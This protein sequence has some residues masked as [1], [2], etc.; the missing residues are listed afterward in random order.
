MTNVNNQIAN[1]DDQLADIKSI[2]FFNQ[3]YAPQ[4]PRLNAKKYDIMSYQASLYLKS[5]EG[6]NVDGKKILDIGC[7][8]GGGLDVFERFY[9][10]ESVHGCDISEKRVQFAK[11]NCVGEIN[12]KVS[13]F[14]SLDYDDSSFDVVTLI[15]TGNFTKD[16]DKI[17]SE[18]KRVLKPNGIFVYADQFAAGKI[19][20]EAMLNSKFSNL[21]KEDITKNVIDS[22]EANYDIFFISD[23]PLSV[24][25]TTTRLFHNATQAYKNT[26]AKYF[27]YKAY[28]E[29]DM[30]QKK[31]EDVLE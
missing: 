17:F 5:L 24:K 31:D 30:I 27:I 12:V 18:V 8:R 7:G 9:N 13:N 4:D 1:L 22:C 26:N 25:R 15:E 11:N 20:H 29:T 2:T 19:E 28:N 3:G 23:F 21:D 6:L 10:F 16:L 14:E